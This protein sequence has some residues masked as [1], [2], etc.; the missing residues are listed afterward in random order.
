MTEAVRS[1]AEL[2]GTPWRNGA[3]VTRPAPGHSV[4]ADR[5]RLIDILID[6]A[7]PD[8]DRTTE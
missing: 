6:V 8:M 5:A 1:V 7:H 3:E 2:P 4:V